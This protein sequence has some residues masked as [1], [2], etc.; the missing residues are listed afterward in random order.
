MTIS[1]ILL[2]AELPLKMREIKDFRKFLFSLN[3]RFM[4]RRYNDDTKSSNLTVQSIYF[5]WQKTSFSGK[6]EKKSIVFG[7]IIIIC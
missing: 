1:S 2:G 7:Y 5:R 4:S 6:N 3:Q